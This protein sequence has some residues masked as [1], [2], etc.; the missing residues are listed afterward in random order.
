MR[1]QVD[2]QP[3]VRCYSISSAPETPGYLEISVRRQGLVSAMLH[4]TV[5]PGSLLAVKPPAGS[6]VYPAGDDRPLV[7][8]AG[9][10]GITPV[11]SMLRHGAA[12]DPNRPI[13]LLYSVR[14]EQDI[15]FRDELSVFVRRHPQV[16]VAITISGSSRSE[17][18]RV[19]RIDEALVADTVT[20]PAHSIFLMC[21]PDPMIDGLRR[22]LADL[23]VPAAQVRSE[24]FQPAAAI[25][26]KRAALA[27]PPPIETDEAPDAASPE[28]DSEGAAGDREPAGPRLLL[29]RSNR[30]VAVE[31]NQTLLEAAESAGAEIPCLCRSGVCGTCRTRLISGDA[32]CTSDALDDEDRAGGF[33]LPCVTWAR[34]DCSLDA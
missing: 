31:G 11:L 19:G 21:G 2:G 16:R 23:G 27:A 25:G 22:L 14:D 4:S 29:A 33:V 18:Y 1:V 7:L 5:R 30:T 28:G 26:A 13:T 15:A 10:V 3:H 20:D 6:F 32:E 34:G 12:A 8:V 9:G 17:R 24:L